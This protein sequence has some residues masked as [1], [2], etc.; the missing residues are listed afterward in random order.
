MIPPHNHIISYRYNPSFS[1]KN[2]STHHYSDITSSPAEVPCF[3]NLP[4]VTHMCWGGCGPDRGRALPACIYHIDSIYVAD[5]GQKLEARPPAANWF[6]WQQK[7]RR[8]ARSELNWMESGN[9]R[10]VE[11]GRTYRPG[12]IYLAPT[13]I[14]GPAA[15][16]AMV[17]AA[18][19]PFFAR[20][21][22]AHVHKN[23]QRWR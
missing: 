20:I 9:S 3:R 23:G 19:R 22:Y 15:T 17:I 16:P 1:P 14:W 7:V 5:G 21:A 6:A 12:R 8:R 11:S 2:R 4:G 18:K 13:S 10:E